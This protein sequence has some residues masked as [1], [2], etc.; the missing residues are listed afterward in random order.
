MYFSKDNVTDEANTTLETNKE[1]LEKNEDEEE[2]KNK[3]TTVKDDDE[4]SEE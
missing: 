3:T 1:D 2:N 4:E